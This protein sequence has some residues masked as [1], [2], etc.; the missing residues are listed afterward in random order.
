M[1]S[2][3]KNLSLIL[4]PLGYKNSMYPSFLGSIPVQV[5]SFS[6]PNFIGRIFYLKA[7]LE[8]MILLSSLLLH[9][10][11]VILAFSSL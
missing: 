6:S 8:S 9:E 4:I 7:S 10:K 11:N 2:K 3:S 5:I 1:E